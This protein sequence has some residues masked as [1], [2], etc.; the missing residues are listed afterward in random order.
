[1]SIK[2]STFA[3]EKDR[4]MTKEEQYQELVTQVA[5]VVAGETDTIA[6]MANVAAIL[7]EAFGF[8]W[9]GFYRVEP[10]VESQKSKEENWSWVRS[11]VRW[12]AHVFLME[13]AYAGRLGRRTR[14]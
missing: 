5:S 9:T 10:I 13:K 6:N 3:A 12:R 1:M 8:W 14:R 4:S 11:K 2:S 7:H